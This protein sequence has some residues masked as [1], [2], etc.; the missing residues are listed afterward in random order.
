MKDDRWLSLENLLR[1]RSY[2]GEKLALRYRQKFIVLASK[3]RFDLARVSDPDD[4]KLGA[5][6]LQGKPV[7]TID[8]MVAS[9][10]L[11]DHDDGRAFALRRFRAG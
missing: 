7:R 5:Q 4:I 8:G 3:F 1:Q 2:A 11:E 9:K 10:S 6:R